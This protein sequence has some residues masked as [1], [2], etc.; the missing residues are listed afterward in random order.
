M[1]NKNRSLYGISI[2]VL[3]TACAPKASYQF[4]SRDLV[5]HDSITLSK[6]LWNHYRQTYAM[7]APKEKEADGFLFATNILFNGPRFEQDVVVVDSMVLYTTYPILRHYDRSIILDELFGRDAVHRYIYI[8]SRKELN[9][10]NISWYYTLQI[11]KN[12]TFYGYS[13]KEV[14]NKIRKDLPYVITHIQKTKEG[15]WNLKTKVYLNAKK[16]RN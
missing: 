12:G 7:L 9:V 3:I 4:M 5:V 2:S 14:Q 10:Y 6:W 11:S 16:A 13:Y 1:I 8:P 15:K